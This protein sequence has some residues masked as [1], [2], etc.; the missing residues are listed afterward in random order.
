MKNKEQGGFEYSE[1]PRELD[2]DHSL[3]FK[4][5]WEKSMIKFSTFDTFVMCLGVTIL[6]LSLMRSSR[7]GSLSAN[8]RAAIN[9][10]S[11]PPDRYILA[12]ILIRCIANQ[13]TT[14]N[15]ILES[16]EKVKGKNNFSIDQVRKILKKHLDFGVIK[17]RKGVF[18]RYTKVMDKRAKYYIFAEEYIKDWVLWNMRQFGMDRA[19]LNDYS[20]GAWSTAENDWLFH[21]IGW[22]GTDPDEF[23][24]AMRKFI[25]D[26]NI[27]YQ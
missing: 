20:E 6:Y 25:R 11:I 17:K 4:K 8:F 16:V 10:S 23:D 9:A 24:E 5:A 15:D 22:Q 12:I 18:N 27:N 1:F 7:L 3:F 13:Q 19:D 21:Y 2:P 26:V 14:E